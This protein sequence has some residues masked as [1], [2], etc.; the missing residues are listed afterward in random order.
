MSEITSPVTSTAVQV[1]RA[2]QVLMA[3]PRLPLSIGVDLGRV[4]LTLGELIGLREGML[5]RVECEPRSELSVTIQGRPFLTGALLERD[6]R[7][8]VRVAPGFEA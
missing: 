6:H 8:A 7:L 3:H 4:R 1:G 2:E 5:L